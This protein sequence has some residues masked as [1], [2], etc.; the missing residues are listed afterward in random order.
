[1][2]LKTAWNV[3]IIIRAPGSPSTGV[4]IAIFSVARSRNPIWQGVS[5]SWNGTRAQRR[6]ATLVTR[7]ANPLDVAV[8]LVSLP[9]YPEGFLRSFLPLCCT[10]RTRPL[11]TALTAGAMR[12][13]GG[14]GLHRPHLTIATST[15]YVSPRLNYAMKLKTRRSSPA[16]QK[17]G[18]AATN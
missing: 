17:F 18:S 2:A 3:L 8:G 5:V 10:K 12:N 14:C 7:A 16:H 11:N 13:N 9:H 4:Q 6:S 1:M 15:A